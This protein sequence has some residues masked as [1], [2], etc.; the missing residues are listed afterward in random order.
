[1]PVSPADLE[2]KRRKLPFN[3]VYHYP[4]IWERI[5]IDVYNF[6]FDR[7]WPVKPWVFGSLSAASAAV[8]LRNPAWIPE[9]LR[10]KSTNYATNSLLLGVGCAAVSVVVVRLFL[11]LFYFRYKRFLFEDPKRPSAAT[12]L[13]QLTFVLLKRFAPPRLRSCDALLPALPV[14]ALRKTIE[15]YLE[16]MEPLMSEEEFAALKAMTDEFLR[17]EGPKL[18]WRTWLYS[19]TA[20]NY[21]TPIWELGYLY[22]REPL[23]VH[24]SICCVDC[25]GTPPCSQPRRGAQMVYGTALN[26]LSFADRSQ[27]PLADG[28]LFSGHY[29][30]LYATARVPGRERD[31]WESVG[32]RTRH[33]VCLAGGCFFKVD[34]FDPRTNRLRSVEELDAILTEVLK[35]NERP[36]EAERRLCALTQDRRDGWAANRERFF[37]ANETNRRFLRTME[38][39][40]IFLILD[41]AEDYGYKAGNYDQLSNF[42]GNMLTGNGAN[43]WTDKPINF[44]I[45]KNGR[46]GACSEHSVADGP[47]YFH[48]T[49]NKFFADLFIGFP[50]EVVDVEKLENFELP[51]DLPPAERMA[52]EVVDGM[53]AE[54]DR[55][56]AE[57]SQLIANVD[58]ASMMFDEWGKGR[59]KTASCGPDA[60]F[61]MA[62]QL[63][64]FKDQG[65][66]TL[67]YEAASTRFFDHSRTETMRSVSRDSCAFVRAMLSEPRDRQLCIRLLQAACAS[68]Q[69]RTRLAM[70]GEGIDRHLFVLYVM[71]KRAGVE[72]AFLEHYIQ[73]RWV[74]STTQI[75]Y[76]TDLLDETPATPEQ[77]WL[78]GSFGAVTEDGYGVAY[79]FVGQHAMIWHVTSYHSAENTSSRR[80]RGLI[81]ESLREMIGLFDEEQ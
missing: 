5:S 2:R 17:S 64:Y 78:G 65:K 20:R 31:H 75:G 54:I 55:C 28:L 53:P 4:S 7:L 8:F 6:V 34:L 25:L 19:W 23:I 22:R 74:L 9:G 43:R 66:F 72:S 41:E 57:A 38:T 24:S 80:L 36:A 47:E 26:M 69:H 58:M 15:R 70:T 35:R 68:H 32:E 50:K 62:I 46:A 12:R 56:Y 37:L 81:E 1:M 76:V 33:F 29:N 13:W 27:R 79:R 59:I 73:Q 40:M 71:S 44:I 10:A 77:C 3:L 67:T 14:P 51:P 16:S 45:G 61:Q 39:A 21:V 30:R 60:F 49:E 63:A 52:I 11:R 18:Q 48:I 42:I